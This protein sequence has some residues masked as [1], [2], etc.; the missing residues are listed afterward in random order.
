MREKETGREWGRQR[1][2]HVFTYSTMGLLNNLQ[3]TVTY[4]AGGVATLMCAGLVLVVAMQEKLLYVPRIPGVPADYIGNPRDFGIEDYEDIW[5]STQDG[6][7]LHAWMLFHPKNKANLL[8]VSNANTGGTLEPTTP[9]VLFFQENAGNISHRLEFARL[10]MNVAS[11]NVMLL[12]YRG[13]G[14]SSGAPSE[15]GLVLDAQAAV[16]HLRQRTDIDSDKIFLFGRSLGG[17]VAIAIAERMQRK[18]DAVDGSSG[19]GAKRDSVQEERAIHARG[20][21]T[22]KGVILENTFTCIADMVMKVMP[23][24]GPLVGRNRP[25]HFLLRNKWDS[26]R[27]IAQLT[28]PVLFI[29][30]E[31]DELVPPAHMHR[32]HELLPETNGTDTCSNKTLIRIM[33]GKHMS[34]WISGKRTYWQAIQNFVSPPAAA[35]PF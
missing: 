5:L 15:E 14:R 34:T 29:V 24:L 21:G 35:Q 4:V 25:L 19:P 23:L 13:Y 3:T 30:G 2:P 16:E 18:G 31:Q 7:S 22:I 20:H 33:D 28:M 1:E 32:L 12:S 8:R 11:V 26:D 6:E 10:L 27:R 17:A 9:T